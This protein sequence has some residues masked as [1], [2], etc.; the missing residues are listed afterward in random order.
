MEQFVKIEQWM[1]DDELGLSLAEMVVFAIIYGFTQG[2][3]GKCIASAEYLAQKT[4]LKSRQVYNV[5]QSLEQKGLISKKQIRM[6]NTNRCEYVATLDHYAKIA[7]CPESIMQKLHDDTA[8][9]AE[10][11]MQKLHNGHY[12][13]IAY[14]KKDIGIEKKV[15]GVV[16]SREHCTTT[17]PDVQSHTL[18]PRIVL[19]DDTHFDNGGI[20]TPK[21]SHP[22]W[23]DIVTKQKAF[24]MDFDSWMERNYPNLLA[25][26]HPLTPYE[27]Y[28]LIVQTKDK[29]KVFLA[30]R[31]LANKP[32]AYL[33]SKASANITIET[34][35]SQMD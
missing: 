16:C 26:S 24:Y 3:D 30:I 8:K 7:E 33:Q 34:F 11:S 32:D 12:A 27:L 22:N 19:E 23:K 25:F 17:P 4:R 31:Q 10:C 14:R 35:I 13:K 20:W 6:N 1:S 28:H 29:D 15:E 21:S 18:D 5:L 2:K 9:I